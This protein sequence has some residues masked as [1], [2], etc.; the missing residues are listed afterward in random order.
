M[1]AS[2]CH[3][4]VVSESMSYVCGSLAEYEL[5]SIQGTE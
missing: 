2:K 3:L 5:H 1:T 4:T